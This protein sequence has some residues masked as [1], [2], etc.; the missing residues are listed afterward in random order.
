MHVSQKY[1]FT[2]NKYKPSFDLRD[3]TKHSGRTP[4]V[5][6][7]EFL[8]F[9]QLVHSRK[10]RCSESLIVPVINQFPIQYQ[11]VLTV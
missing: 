6:T 4:C 3:K 8:G 10:K 11:V 7:S 5:R 2:K 9:S 1:G